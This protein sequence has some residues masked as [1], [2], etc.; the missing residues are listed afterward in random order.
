MRKLAINRCP[1]AAARQSIHQSINPLISERQW[2]VCTDNK[3][4]EKRKRGRT[5]GRTARMSVI[6]I[7][8]VHTP[9][10]HC[11]RAPSR[12]CHFRQGR[13]NH[14]ANCSMAWGPPL[15]AL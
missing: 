10:N 7:N 2:P 9:I 3:K 14:C 13:I 6:R 8:N 4:N 11:L 1:V 12:S 15:G 5:D